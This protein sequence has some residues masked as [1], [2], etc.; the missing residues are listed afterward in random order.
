MQRT[1]RG[2]ALK[3]G[4]RLSCYGIVSTFALAKQ[5]RI[6]GFDFGGIDEHNRNV[7]LD[8]IKAVA[9]LAFQAT[10]VGLK[11]DL[12]FADRA[13]EDIEKVFSNHDGNIVAPYESF[14]SG[15][16]ANRA[17]SAIESQVRFSEE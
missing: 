3:C 5:S 13:D 6:S 12:S 2:V 4:L 15:C 8:R 11:N 16:T 7:I 1:Q 14:A 9:L 17:A 10:S